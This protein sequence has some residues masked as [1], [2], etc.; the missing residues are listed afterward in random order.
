MRMKEVG[1]GVVDPTASWKV[2]ETELM[3]L[4]LVN[5]NESTTLIEPAF[6]PLQGVLVETLETSLVVAVQTAPPLRTALLYDCP[7]VPVLLSLIPELN[8]L[9]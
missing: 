4:P 1:S 7:G 6:R 2:L 9:I 5:V 8:A 3:P